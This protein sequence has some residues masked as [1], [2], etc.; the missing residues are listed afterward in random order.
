MEDTSTVFD[1]PVRE[2]FFEETIIM[3][4]L[5]TKLRAVD[6]GSDHVIE[7]PLMNYDFVSSDAYFIR[8]ERWIQRIVYQQ[9]IVFQQRCVRKGTIVNTVPTMSLRCL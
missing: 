7:M 9:R 1:Q 4:I 8:V 2:I 6:C 3:E 5:G